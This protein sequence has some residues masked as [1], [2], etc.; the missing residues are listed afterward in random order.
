M[1]SMAG[2]ANVGDFASAIGARGEEAAVIAELKAGSEDAYAW[3]VGEFH[4]PVYSV[5]Y[6]ILTDPADAADTTQ[7]VFLKVF[8]GMK[9][10]HG[11]SSLKTWI[12]R[13]A[14]HEA[15][16][17]R[18]WWFRHKSK[19]TSV[20]PGETTFEYSSVAAENIAFVDK[21]KSPFDNAVDH[22]LKAR[23]EEELRQVSEPYRTAVV[24][25]DIE[26]LSYEEIAEITQVSLGTV[27]SRITRGRDAL[28]KRLS[29]YVRQAGTE[30]GLDIDSLRFKPQAV[31]QVERGS[32]IEVTP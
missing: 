2:A 26:E 5:I 23:V 18:R 11:E 16:N 10:F 30:L 12:Y 9:Y 31:S 25:R 1:A 4:Q 28:R 27:K 7:E 19:E 14:I 24:L 3:L 21:R 13:I 22:E 29:E 15:S 8:R 20:E 17:R 6:R 32:R